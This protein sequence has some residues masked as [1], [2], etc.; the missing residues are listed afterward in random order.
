MD[1]NKI[2]QPEITAKKL[3][4][5]YNEVKAAW[6]P[7]HANFKKSGSHSSWRSFSG[8]EQYPDC[9]EILYWQNGRVQIRTTA[10]LDVQ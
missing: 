7:L 8:G 6:N 2:K 10:V 3:Y 4:D 9:F 5:M 1:P